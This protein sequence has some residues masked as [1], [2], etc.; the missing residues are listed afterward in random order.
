[1][2]YRRIC[3]AE[4]F[5]LGCA[6]ESRWAGSVRP[7]LVSFFLAF[8]LNPPA[9]RSNGNRR[10]RWS[11]A[12]TKLIG[13]T[14]GFVAE[15]TILNVRLVHAILFISCFNFSIPGSVGW[16]DRAEFLC[17]ILHPVHHY[18]CSPEV[19]GPP[20]SPSF[21]FPVKRMKGIAQTVGHYVIELDQCTASPVA[22]ERVDRER[23]TPRLFPSQ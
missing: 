7:L 1:M 6:G 5:V 12:P 15:W 13:S 4:S 18:S 17:V 20:L 3:Q 23:V 16:H 8:D 19:Q 11:S 14:S 2:R 10:T 22:R 9:T 21:P